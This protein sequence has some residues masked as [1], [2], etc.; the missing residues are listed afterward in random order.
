MVCTSKGQNAP[1]VARKISLLRVVL[2]PPG[3]AV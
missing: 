3:K 2:E 1:K